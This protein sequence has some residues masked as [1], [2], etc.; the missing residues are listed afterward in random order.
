MPSNKNTFD[1]KKYNIG[2]NV[3][4]VFIARRSINYENIERNN[5]S[6]YYRSLLGNINYFPC[7]INGFIFRWQTTK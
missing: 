7:D 1:C 6:F 4:D 5:S 2:D 3:R